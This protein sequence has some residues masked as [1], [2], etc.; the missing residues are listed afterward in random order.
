VNSKQ[1]MPVLN[2]M[3]S[4]GKIEHIMDKSSSA[5][6]G[7]IYDCKISCLIY[8]CNIPDKLVGSI[9]T[10]NMIIYRRQH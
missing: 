6:K 7:Q 5:T 1:T 10:K 3:H 2:T 8:V 4:F 9:T